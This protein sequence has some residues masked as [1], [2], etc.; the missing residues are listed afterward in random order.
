MHLTRIKKTIINYL[1]NNKFSFNMISTI[2]KSIS[3]PKNVAIN[4]QKKNSK[5]KEKNYFF[6]FFSKKYTELIQV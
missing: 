5:H 3:K 4:K 6:K 2:I 1:N